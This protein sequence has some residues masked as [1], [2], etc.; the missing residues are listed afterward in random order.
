MMTQREN[1][2][3]ALVEVCA[4]LAHEQVDQAHVDELAKSISDDGELRCPVI[5]DR[6]SFVI[7]DGHHR[8]NALKRLGCR[9][10][11]AYL[12]DYGCDSVR[13]LPRR[14]GLAVD[15]S[16]IVRAAMHGELFPVKS[17]RHVFECV[18][19]EHPVSLAAMKAISNS[20]GTDSGSVARHALDRLVAR[21][22]D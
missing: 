6:Q 3:F 16:S 19:A 15:K 22:A 9:L 7:L 1:Y 8:V 12:L 14:S 17:S 11:P 21:E 20:A 18:P 10:V 13:V 2:V 4:L 5:V